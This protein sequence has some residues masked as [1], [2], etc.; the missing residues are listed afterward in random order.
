VLSADG[1]RLLVAAHHGAVDGLGLLGI[2]R[3]L[4]DRDLRSAARGI[5]DRRAPVGFLRSS[6]R[7]LGEALVS[8]PVR[9]RGAGE[10]GSSREDLTAHALPAG[11]HGTSALAAAVLATH[12]RLHPE[13]RGHAVLAVGASRRTDPRPAPDRQTAYLRLRAATDLPAAE[14]AALL[15]AVPPEPDFPETSAGGVGPLVTRALRSRLGSTATLSNLGV[16][17]G[18]LTSAAMYPALNGPR[19][20]GVGLATAGDTTM[21]TLR[22][23]RRDFTAAEHQH[24]VTALAEALLA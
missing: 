17:E 11:R 24:L 4:L 3:E 8:P 15:A 6:V 2:A 9:F 12:R 7:R 16:L 18:P 10:R 20:V 5:G 14:V 23:R 19:A 1:R 21:L 13:V 22:T